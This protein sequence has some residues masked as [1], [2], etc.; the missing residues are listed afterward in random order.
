VN[1]EDRDHQRTAR[2]A[3]VRTETDALAHTGRGCRLPAG[4]YLVAEID[5]AAARNVAY[6]HGPD[7]D[8]VCVWLA[9]PDISYETGETP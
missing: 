2:Y 6:V 5:G 7:G 4:R 8:L 3:H 9:N 1:F